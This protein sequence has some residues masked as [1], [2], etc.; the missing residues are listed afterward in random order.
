MKNTKKQMKFLFV[1]MGPGETAQGEALARYISQ[2]GHKIVFCLKKEVNLH[3]LKK[4]KDFKVII[5]PPNSTPKELR[6]I[7]EK[8]KFDV[9]I[10]CNSKIWSRYKKFTEKPLSPAPFLS[11]TLDSNWLFN[12]KK[13]PRFNFI[14]WVDK[15]F[16]LFPQRIF[17]LGLK[18]N[19]GHFNI[20]PEAL[21]KI[22]PVGF[23]PSYQKP[24]VTTIK[25]IRKEYNLKKDE[26][27]IFS[28][29][30]GFGAGY[31]FFAFKNLIKSVSQLISKGRKIKV[32][33]VGPTENLSQETLAKKWLIIKG[34]LSAQ[35][36]FLNLA[37][38]DLVFQHQGMV[39][40]SQAISATVPVIC[41]VHILKKKSIPY[42]HFWEVESFKKVGA[43][44][45]A[46]KSTSSQELVA[47]L[48]KLLYNEK[49][50]KKM[51]KAQ[52]RIFE[53]GEEKAFQIIQQLVQKKQK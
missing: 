9:I 15:Y 44:E 36:Y 52:K 40:L 23:I 31:R 25:Q 29:F 28:Y 32:I 43:C 51:Q 41:N 14:K 47:K 39:T 46:S 50:K 19:G 48:N 16:I 8:E 12:S 18:Q 4:D 17:E 11:F 33:Y 42:L 45:M 20:S 3:F 24:S 34:K 37:S 6:K 10:F 30:S 27:L 22:V 5:L 13:Y 26:K 38:S 53:R 1:S 21:S 2:K 35:D 49:E 7:I